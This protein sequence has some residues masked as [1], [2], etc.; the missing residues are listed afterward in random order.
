MSKKG[1]TYKLEDL[2]LLPVLKL[3]SNGFKKLHDSIFL[4]RY[5]IFIADLG[6]EVNLALMGVSSG[7]GD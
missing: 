1:R 2:S 7:S 5:S 3:R 6:Y 4:V